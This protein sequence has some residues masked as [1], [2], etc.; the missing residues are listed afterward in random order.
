M[1]IVGNFSGGKGGVGKTSILAYL[2][3]LVSSTRSTLIVDASSEGGISN[4]MLGN[5]SPPFL[6][7][8][9]LKK[10]SLYEIINTYEVDISNDIKINFNMIANHGIIDFQNNFIDILRN[11]PLIVKKI[12]YIFLDFPT[13]QTNKIYLDMLYKCD[14]VLKIAEPTSQSINAI[15]NNIFKKE[16]YILN[17]PHPYPSSLI[18]EAVK[19]LNKKGIRDVT[20]FPYDAAVSIA[21]KYFPKTLAH[22][23]KQFTSSL[24][25][26]ALKIL[27]V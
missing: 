1:K 7:D 25:N 8:Y 4:L 3:L 2:G 22:L 24:R 5:S 26:L 27:K 17:S 11:D 19:I 21:S 13:F 20:I 9:F 14:I 10:Y 23:S 16:I 12:E 18:N 15:L 6:R